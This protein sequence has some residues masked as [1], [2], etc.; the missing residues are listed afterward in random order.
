MRKRI[1][2]IIVIVLK[3]FIS[4][5]ANAQS[6]IAYYPLNGNANDAS[7]NSLNG[8]VIGSPAFVTD[9]FGNANSAIAFSNNVADRIEINDNALLH[10]PSITIAAWVREIGVSSSIKTIVD[11]PLGST[12]SDSW[13]FGVITNGGYVYTSWFFNDPGSSTGSQITALANIG[14]W[15]YVVATFDNS[16]KLHK[17]YVDG[18]LKATNTFN[19][20]IGYDNNKM[21]IGA[22]LENNSPSFP[23]DGELDEIKI[24]DGALSAQQIANEYSAGIAYSNTGSGNAI[25]FN[26]SSNDYFAQLPS[27]LDG[28]NVFTVDFWVK[29]TDNNSH[30]TY[31]LKPALVGNANPSS[32]D[33]DF[34]IT[35]NNGQIGVWSGISSSGDNDL[36]TAKSINDDKWH[37]VAAVSDGVNMVL[38]VDGILMPGSISTAGGT[39]QTA[40]RPWYIGKLNSCCS[41]GSP[42]NATI[43]EFRV[44]DAALTQSQIRDRMCRKIDNSDALYSNLL[45]VYHFNETIGTAIVDSKNNNNGFLNLGTRLVSGAAVGNASAYDYTNTIKTTSISHASGESFT[46]TSASGNPDGIQVYRV[47]E[48]PNT[49]SGSISLGA[50]NKYFGVF[51]AGGVSPQYNAVYNYTGNADVTAGNESGLVL[52]KRADNA[53]TTWTNGAATLDMNANT[54]SLA[55]ESTEYILG[56]SS[57]LPLHLL[58]FTATKQD[59]N[60]LLQW[61]TADEINTS[62]FEIE[63]SNDALAFDRIG[64]K[65]AANSSGT[66]S[67]SFTD[68]KPVSGINYYR[69]KQVDKDGRY[70]YSPT[71]KL[72]FE[73]NA[74][75]LNVYPNPARNT[76]TIAYP[77]NQ[78][79]L[80]LTIFDLAGR[81]VMNKELNS[82]SLLHLDVS[83]LTGGVYTLR[84]ND[85][86]KQS[87]SKFVK[88]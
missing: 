29:T 75:E 74:R 83:N 57:T 30:P 50:M 63:R 12:Q 49:L 3:L 16:T 76:I 1:L 18:I 85:G 5:Q 17:L 81:Q 68:S 25:Y 45:A 20:T 58:S 14:D 8:T 77:G 51:Q 67:Y 44:W 33:G 2:P 21:Y 24:Y 15:H 56:I 38:Y 55:G 11:K 9:R 36:Q 52:Y 59:A 86:V 87:F 60:A 53:V 35:L 40:A 84:L 4:Q 47:D 66:H 78:K 69:L 28:T 73:S 41:N 64:T 32:Q 88:L 39:L 82:Q 23:M 27:L 48:Q 34:G 37:H 26:G 19:N 80:T 43:D 79:K 62:H 42:S 61:Q 70:T 7:G 31:W 22:A 10:T 46:V 6:L 65:T 54:L 71:V 72:V 13:H